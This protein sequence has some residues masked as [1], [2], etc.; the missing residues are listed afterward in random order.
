ME[1]PKCLVKNGALETDLELIP[2]K[3]ALRQRALVEFEL[4]RDAAD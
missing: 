2:I 4:G 1:T 3:P